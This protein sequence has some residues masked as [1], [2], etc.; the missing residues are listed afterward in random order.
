[1][2]PTLLTHKF[3]L[4]PSGFFNPESA[5][6]MLAEVVDLSGDAVIRHMDIAQY[7]AVLIYSDIS[8]GSDLVPEMFCIL[9]DL[10][11]CPEYNKVLCSWIDGYIY[12]AIAQ[13]R[14]LS[15][16]NAYRAADF[17]TAEYYVFL[18]MKSLQLNP[19]VTTICWRTP[20]GPDEEMSLYRYFKSVEHI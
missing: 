17:T 7:G 5:R 20:L 12:L 3:T 4:V 10:P 18:A 2:E 9:R 1:M 11:S 8:G 16:A 19:E 14:N 6:D 13:G 15:L